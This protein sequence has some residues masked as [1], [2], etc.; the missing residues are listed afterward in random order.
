MW[1]KNLINFKQ[2]RCETLTQAM[3]R[4]RLFS[5]GAKVNMHDN[6]FLIGHFISKLH[7]VK[8]QEMVQATITRNLPSLVSAN[9]N[10][11]GESVYSARNLPISLPKEWNV[12]E[13]ILIKEMA[14]LE[15]ALL[16]ILKDKKKEENTKK[17]GEH[18][19]NANT[20]KRKMI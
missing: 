12:L 11:T 19:D 14:N 18:D 5:L 1:F 4:Y 10:T 17:L 3:D 6:T 13:S 20:K 16:N 2:E 8:F 9:S 15:S 7:T